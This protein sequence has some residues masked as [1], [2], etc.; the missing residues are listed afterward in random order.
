MA[1]S[2]I[3]ASGE[4]LKSCDVPF[5]PESSSVYDMAIST[6][7]QVIFPDTP[8]FFP[9]EKDITV[10]YILA[11]I[12]PS[13]RDWVGLFRVGWASPRDYSTYVW[14]P[15]PIA[16]ESGNLSQT[17]TFQAY[18]LPKDDNEFYQLCY[19]TRQGYVR[20]A[21]TPFQF[22]LCTENDCLVEVEDES[23]MIILK[24]KSDA[25]EEQLSKAKEERNALESEMKLLFQA[26]V[27]L[28]ENL[29]K[30]SE[31]LAMAQEQNRVSEEK[32]ADVVASM[33][34]MTEEYEK[35]T[36]RLA[37]AEK[38]IEKTKADL[39]SAQNNIK[40]LQ[41]SMSSLQA[42][43]VAAEQERLQ[44]KINYEEEIKIRE[45]MM[46]EKDVQMNV[47][48][49]EIKTMSTIKEEIQQKSSLKVNEQESAFKVVT[50]ENENLRVKCQSLKDERDLFKDQFTKSEL[51]RNE[52]LKDKASLE[53]KLQ[54]A[55][56]DAEMQQE[57]VDA[58]EEKIKVVEKQWKELNKKHKIETNH[59]QDEL[60]NSSERANALEAAKK[61]LTQELSDT[62]ATRD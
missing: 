14:A 31:E 10:R 53:E 33:E 61:L 34:K 51:A 41:E 48:R 7:S 12:E 9:P 13:T 27:L 60:R 56:K 18:Q 32:K 11:E 50:K 55:I 24:T 46:L 58:A 35:V 26:K 30:I 57:K 21:S 5:I 42:Q 22:R 20:G 28:E 52:A 4:M 15:K 36:H 37:K 39:A 8:D 45:M 23:G 6:F 25:L 54:Y 40:E 59:V 44:E 19:V 49:E 43:I 38:R 62:T 16:D 29:K 2:E 47:L 3:E 1:S 17:I